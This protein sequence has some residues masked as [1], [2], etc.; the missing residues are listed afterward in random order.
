[1]QC[2]LKANFNKTQKNIIYIQKYIS[3]CG[4]MIL[5]AFDEKLCLC[6]W[7]GGYRRDVINRR[8]QRRWNAVFE[9]KS[10]A[11]L[12]S[13]VEQLD[14]YFNGWRT[15]FTIPLLFCGSDFQSAVWHELLTIPYGKTISYSAFARKLGI[16]SAVRAVANANGANAISI[17]VPCHRV[18]GSNN[19]LT[20][21]GGG[22]DAKRY[23][24]KMESTCDFMRNRR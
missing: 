18:I 17:I 19:S 15:N 10:I 9:E 21:Y 6:D 11:V 2:S 7:V 14:E 20:G 22:L 4:E 5:G 23:L 24:L 12:Q 3:P 13:T 8:I 16:P 1:M